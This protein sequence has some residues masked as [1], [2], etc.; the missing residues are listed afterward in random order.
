[1]QNVLLQ[2]SSRQYVIDVCLLHARHVHMLR[3]TQDQLERGS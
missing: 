3:F 1:M 2:E